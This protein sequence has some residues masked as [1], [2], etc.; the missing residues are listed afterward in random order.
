M[1]KE[2]TRSLKITGYETASNDLRRRP[3]RHIFNRGTRAQMKVAI[4]DAF[5]DLNPLLNFRLCKVSGC[6]I[7]VL[8]ACSF[9]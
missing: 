8:L 7:L 1:I 9:L 4:H 3:N 2:R 5:N 6:R